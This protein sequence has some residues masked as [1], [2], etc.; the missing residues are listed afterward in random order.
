MANG[1]G[2]GG[3][4]DKVNIDLNKALAGVEDQNARALL[5]AL[6]QDNFGIKVSTGTYLYPT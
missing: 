4:R 1:D 6:V 5:A 3:E 2:S